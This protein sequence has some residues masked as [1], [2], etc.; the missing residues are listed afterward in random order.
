MST[1][2]PAVLDITGEHTNL[3]EKCVYC[4]LIEDL[5]GL[6][7]MLEDSIAIHNQEFTS[8]LFEYAI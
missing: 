2:D 6:C 3:K 1:C 4:R 5:N 8:G 7:I